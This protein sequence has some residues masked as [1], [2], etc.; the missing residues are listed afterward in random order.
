MKHS[1]VLV[2]AFCACISLAACADEDAVSIPSSSSSSTTSEASSVSSA[3]ATTVV[4]MTYNVEKFDKG[5]DIPSG[6][7]AAIANTVKT[8]STD[9][10][11]LCEVESSGN[12]ETSFSSALT[13]AGWAMNYHAFSSMSDDYNSIG[14]FS[15][16]PVSDVSEILASSTRTV[17]RYKVTVGSSAIWLYGC[18]LKSGT[19]STAESRRKTEAQALANYIRANHD[20][21]SEYIV[22]LGD[23]NTMNLGDWSQSPPATGGTSTVDYLELRD[24]S[25][26]S[27]NFTSL[28]RVK[29]TINYSNGT[30]NYT[31]TWN[32]PSGLPLDHIIL[33]PALYARYISETKY[34]VGSGTASSNPTDHYVITLR[35]TL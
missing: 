16:Y 9:I 33:S 35:V 28:T 6:T 5:G 23:M 1:P 31:T 3:S 8:N 22:I 4:I 30:S 7:Y 12:D 24:D 20:E 34:R 27:N 17:Y 26:A 15:R 13:T 10:I 11:N 21:S 19:D 29:A 2:I 18:H 25:D 14:H 32:Y